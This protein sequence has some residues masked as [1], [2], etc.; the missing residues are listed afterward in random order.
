L[1]NTHHNQWSLQAE[2]RAHPATHPRQDFGEF[3]PNTT[4]VRRVAADSGKNHQEHKEHKV[5]AKIYRPT[6]I[7][8]AR[9]AFFVNFVPFVVEV[10]FDYQM[11]T[12]TYVVVS[13]EDSQISAP[14]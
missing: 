3:S 5:K 8:P 11:P 6:H 10:L 2:Q 14:G 7:P 1:V 12:F 13:A 4:E 9:S